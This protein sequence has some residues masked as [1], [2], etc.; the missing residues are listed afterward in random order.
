MSKL[1]TVSYGLGIFGPILGW[2]AAM[3]YLMYFY[4][5]VVGLDPASAG[6]VFMIG[7]VWDAVSDPLIGWLADRTRTRWGRFRPYLVIGALPY[8]LGLALAFNPQRIGIADMFVAALVTHLVFRT[9][10]TLLVIPYTAML[11]R[12]SSD[13]D[14]RTLLTSVKTAFIFVGN[15]IIS[16]GFFTLVLFAGDGDEAAGF[17]IS[18]LIFGIIAAI[19]SL[20]CFAGT[21]EPPI[22]DAP[23][24]RKGSLWLALR[25]LVGNRAF[26]VLFAGTAIFGGFYGAEI[27]MTTYLAK[28]WLGDAGLARILF[29]AQAIASLATVPVWYWIGTR[30]G[31]GAVWIGAILLTAFGMVLLYFVRPDNVWVMAAFYAVANIGGS[32]FVL[33]FYAIAADT[34][35]WGEWRTGRRQEGIIFGAISFANKLAAGLATGMVGTA[36]VWVGFVPNAEP[37]AETLDGMFLIG[38]LAPALAFIVAASLWV[39]YPLS[40]D[41]HR[42]I[43]AEIAERDG[44]QSAA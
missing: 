2:V 21:S 35:D 5:D 4:T 38:T 26:M 12:I 27:S 8:A 37:S 29:T 42:A 40:R 6:L 14:G 25:D 28:Y 20:L 36:L 17:A 43:L 11:S 7:M 32:G 34:V 18:A 1:A 3:Q 44:A 39:F 31:K 41:K 13:Y 15:L 9:A 33:I 24:E 23:R 19:T 16:L 22:V 30:L 10:Y